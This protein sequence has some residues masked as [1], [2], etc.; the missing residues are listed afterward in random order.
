MERQRRESHGVVNRAD[1]SQ[2][3]AA[4]GGIIMS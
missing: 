4:D 1:E 2:A 3:R